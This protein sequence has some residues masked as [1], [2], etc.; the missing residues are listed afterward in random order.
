MHS[1]WR[2]YSAHTVCRRT[3]VCVFVF[4]PPGLAARSDPPVVPSCPLGVS[5]DP[6][7]VP[8]GPAG[9]YWIPLVPSGPSNNMRDFKSARKRCKKAKWTARN[10]WFL[11]MAGQ[12]NVSLLPGKAGSTSN[13]GATWTTVRKLKLGASKWKPWQHQDVRNAEGIQAST[14]SQN[15]D[16]FAAFYHDLFDNSGEA[17]EEAS[18]KWCEQTPVNS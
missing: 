12:C 11:D 2:V 6:P 8:S 14:P 18:S 3:R 7:A 15:A 17:R 9:V 4:N 10:N 1:V 16:N 5:P 13:P